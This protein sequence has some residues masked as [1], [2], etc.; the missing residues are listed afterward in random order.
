MIVA[1]A[2]VIYR[3]SASII[4]ASIVLLSAI[5]LAAETASE[6]LPEARI[7]LVIGNSA[8]PNV[9]L[10]NPANDARDISAALKKLGFQV[11]LVIDGDLAAMSRAIRDFGAAIK[12]PDAVA[13]FYYSGHGVQYRGANYLIPAKADIQAPDELSFSAVNAEQIYAKMEASG[14]RTNIVLLD[15]CRNNPFPGSERASER[16]L[17]VVGTIQPPQSL[18]VYATAPGKTAQDGEGRNGV[19][20]S[21]LLKHLSDPGLDVEIMFRRVRDEVISATGGAQVPWTNS[22]LS[23][24]GFIFVP[25]K[26]SAVA[27]SKPTGGLANTGT[28]SITSDPAGMQ[29][30]VDGAAPLE[31]P[32]SLDLP[33]GAHSFEIQKSTVNGFIYEGEQKQWITVTAGSEASV[34][35]LPRA[36]K[37]MLLFESVPPGYSVFINDEKLGETPLFTTEVQAGSFLLRAE[38]KGK[39]S[40]KQ[41]C[42]VQPGESYTLQWG[43]R[44]ETALELP[45]ASIAFEAKSDSWEGIE[46]IIQLKNSSFL[47]NPGYGVKALYAC[48]DDKYLYWR[49]DFQ[50]ANPFSKAPMGVGKGVVLQ[51]SIFLPSSKTYL[52]IG[53]RQNRE[54]GKLESYV[55]TNQM[56]MGKWNTIAE[57]ILSTKQGQ[58]MIVS[59]LDL[60]YIRKYGIDPVPGPLTLFLVNL[61]SSW[62]WSRKEEMKGPYV[63]FAD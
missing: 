60:S 29:V 57:N 25:A 48:R 58:D 8:Y 39:P 11:N 9:P 46:P 51:L 50:E 12:R 2:K 41:A 45:R 52:D 19:F 10:K 54:K 7:A 6:T 13:L 27:V 42:S 61:D 31:T 20:S 40:V 44:P 4:I 28:L 53:L 47:G 17:A 34:P 18:I 49:V 3:R 1:R 37:A 59:R 16:G 33:P 35:V 55:G 56:P 36:A 23:G 24:K 63:D 26:A 43:K 22:S 38:K 32:I 5:P 15:A 62:K 30:S 14:D 21:A